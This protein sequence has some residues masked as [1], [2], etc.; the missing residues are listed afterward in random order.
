MTSGIWDELESTEINSQSIFMAAA[1][2]TQNFSHLY[3]HL[4]CK[5]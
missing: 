3:A 4:A 5:S 2:S 1:F